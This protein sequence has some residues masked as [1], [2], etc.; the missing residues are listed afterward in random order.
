MKRILI[1]LLAELIW[2]L[3]TVAL[4]QPATRRPD[5]VASDSTSTRILVAKGQRDGEVCASHR[6]SSAGWLVGG[7]ASGLV[8]PVLAPGLVVGASQLGSPRP[9]ALEEHRALQQGF[10]YYQA[11]CKGYAKRA[12]QKALGRSL[13]GGLIIT[14]V[15]AVAVVAISQSDGLLGSGTMTY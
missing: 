9:P 2:L 5:S 4:G 7:L 6:Y 13:I 14:A 15:T 3:P 12:H 1:I 11:F 10:A 8:M